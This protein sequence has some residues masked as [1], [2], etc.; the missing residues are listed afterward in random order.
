MLDIVA[1]VNC[2]PPKERR[3]GIRRRTFDVYWL[4]ALLSVRVLSETR[5]RVSQHP[6]NL[7]GMRPSTELGALHDLARIKTITEVALAIDSKILSPVRSTSMEP[8]KPN[9]P[10][11]ARGYGASSGASIQAGD[12]MR[13]GSSAVESDV[14]VYFS[15]DVETDGPIPGP[16]SMLSFALVVAGTFDGKT[17]TRPTD[18]SEHLYVELRPISQQFQE[19]A[20]RVNGLDRSRLSIHGAEPPVAMTTASEWIRNRSR[21]GR[22]VLVAYPLSFDWTWLY[23]YFVQFSKHGSPFDH[24]RCYDVKTAFAVKSGI[25]ISRAGRSR[26]PE[27]LRGRHPHTHHAVDDAIEQAELFA[28][29]FE[30]NGR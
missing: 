29:L 22:P 7:R 6:R 3:S 1:E 21:G 19:E 28:N 18:Y 9:S 14:D 30:W 4:R 8:P 13:H 16:F 10:M 27:K 12:S 26:I 2:F 5:R 23:W 17:F 20:L 15:A 24:S 25:P 11:E